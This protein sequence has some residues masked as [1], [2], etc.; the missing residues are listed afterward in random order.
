MVIFLVTMKTPISSHMKD[1]DSIFTAH[2][3]DMIFS[4]WNTPGIH[5]CLYNIILL[6]KLWCK[7]DIAVIAQISCI[8]NSLLKTTPFILLMLT[9]KNFSQP[10]CQIC[11]LENNI[12][13]HQDNKI[14]IP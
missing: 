1:K 14:L 11:L 2:D 9:R 4:N 12:F 8:S 10:L 7:K 6:Y 13:R 3:E 5:W